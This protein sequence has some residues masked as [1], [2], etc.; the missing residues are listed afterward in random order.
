MLKKEV[1]L[2]KDL[3]S[4]SSFSG[5]EKLAVDFLIKKTK[6]LNFDSVKR[7][8]AGNFVAVRGQG[9]KQILLVGHIDTVKGTIPVKLIK[10]QLYGRG[11]VD[12]KGSLAAFIWAVHSL[13]NL[14]NKKIVIIGAVEEELPS[15]RGA[16]FILN[17]YQPDYIII[18]EPSGWSNITIGYRGIL[19]FDYS[20]KRN[21]THFAG[22]Q[23]SV[24]Q[25]AFE[26]INELNNYLQLK[27]GNQVPVFDRPNLEIRNINT[28]NN[29]LEEKIIAELSVRLPPGFDIAQLENF[30]TF[31]PVMI[32]EKVRGVIKDKNNALVRGFLKFIRKY[33]GRPK[34]IKKTGTADFNILAENWP[35]VPMVAYG[36]G[37]SKFDH[38]PDEHLNLNEYIKSIHILSNTLQSL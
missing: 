34:F 2:L 27:N 10:Q 13:K 28:S 38:T 25:S 4:I 17:K 12:A 21:L 24:A 18:G 16:R 7:D 11:A 37:D 36:P 31:T 32:K 30:L 15:S 26:F 33:R 22:Q 14:N 19:R 20:L 5:Q 3:L 1:S 9:K 8:Q 29:G 6:K 35:M 23:A